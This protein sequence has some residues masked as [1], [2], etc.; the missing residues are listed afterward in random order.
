[1]QRIPG[2]QA[3]TAEMRVRVLASLRELGLHQ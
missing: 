2:D 1:M 3:T